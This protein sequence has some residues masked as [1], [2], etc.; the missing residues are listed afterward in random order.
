[1]KININRFRRYLSEITRSSLGLKIIVEQDKLS[2]GSM[3]LKAAKYILIELA[4][5]ISNCLQ[6]ILEFPDAP[7]VL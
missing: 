7:N 5:A 3:E 4:E 1:M 6:H 2:P